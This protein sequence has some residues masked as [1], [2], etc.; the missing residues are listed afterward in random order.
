[1]EN[2][3][4]K[5]FIW[6]IENASCVCTNSFHATAFSTIFR[7][8]LIHIPNSKSPERTTSLLERVGIELKTDKEFPFYDIGLCDDTNLNFE[9]EKSKKFLDAVMESEQYGN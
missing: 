8:K 2:V 6:L 3:G 1:M 7:K 9:I 5:E 4:P